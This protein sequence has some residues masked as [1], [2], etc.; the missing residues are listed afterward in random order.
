MMHGNTNVKLFCLSVK[1]I[2]INYFYWDPLSRLSQEQESFQPVT[3]SSEYF[4]FLIAVGRI[5]ILPTATQHKRVTYTNCCIYR[6]ALPD[7]DQ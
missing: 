3:I 4:V 6:V 5:G 1:S 2:G 7:D